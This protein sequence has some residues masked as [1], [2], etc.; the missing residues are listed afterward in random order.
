MGFTKTTA[1]FALAILATSLLLSVAESAVNPFCGT[2]T[3]K[4]LC[5]QMTKDAK[6]WEGA[7]TNVLNA[8]LEKVMA[9]KKIVDG[10]RSKLP[11]NLKQVSKDS[12]QETCSE[13]YDSIIHDITKCIGFVKNDPTS[14]LK[15]YLGGASFSGCTDGLD[16][17]QVS[18]PEVT[19]L[20]A[21]ITKLRSTLLTVAGKKP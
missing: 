4:A 10:V 15:T 20:D 8:A 21:E 6:T 18:L 1:S 11:G 12:I 3:D 2:A 14:A 17:F 13:A 9:G 19:N 7:M 16:E 5:T